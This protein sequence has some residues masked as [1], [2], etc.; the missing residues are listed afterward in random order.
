[1]ETF[2]EIISKLINKFFEY[3]IEIFPYFLIA[4]IIGAL[5]QSYISFKI[6]RKFVNHKILSPIAT[7]VFGASVPV[8]SCSMIPI[9]Q[10][11]NSLSKSF[12]PAISF[13]I[14]APILSPVIFLLMLGMFG[15]KLTIFRFIFGLFLAVFSAYTVN[16]FFKKSPMLPMFS[17]SGENEN[18]W[19]KFKSAFKEIFIGT[20]KFVLIGLLIASAVSVLIPDSLITKFSNFPFSYLLITS[21]SI[22]IYVCS[23]EE[24]P[25]AKSFLDLGL[26]EGQ[27]LTFMLASAGICIPTISATFKIFPKRLVVFYISIWFLG[28]IFSGLIYDTLF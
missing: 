18:R 4:T 17:S 11:I 24:I 7:A 25:I 9:A 10:T 13:L 2:L 14:S 5:I 8:C 26:T 20:G 22:P 23:G 3:S 12:A 15:W 6:V 1:M 27:I 21:F 19:Q 28:S 16:I